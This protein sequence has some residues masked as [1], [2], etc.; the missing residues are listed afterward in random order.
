MR[1]ERG[2]GH[3]CHHP[4]HVFHHRRPGNIDDAVTDHDFRSIDNDDG[5]R[6]LHYHGVGTG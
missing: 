2:F 1:R 3:D 5:G 4:T 6:H